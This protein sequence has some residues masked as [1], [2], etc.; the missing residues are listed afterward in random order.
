MYKRIVVWVDEMN[1]HL[2][3]CKWFG[4]QIEAIRWGANNFHQDHPLFA[5]YIDQRLG[6][7]VDPTEREALVKDWEE[8]MINHLLPLWDHAANSSFAPNDTNADLQLDFGMWVSSSNVWFLLW[9]LWCEVLLWIFFV[10][11]FVTLISVIIMGLEIAEIIRGHNSRC[12]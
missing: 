6:T 8:V 10:C 3:G 7:A 2:M 11:V 5:E 12:K 1:V 9:I 4:L